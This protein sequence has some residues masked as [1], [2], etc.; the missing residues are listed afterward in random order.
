[1][2]AGLASPA[3]A[4]PHIFVDARATITFDDAGQVVSVHNSWTFD[5]YY[6]SWAVQGLD[7]DLDGTV[8]T[9]EMQPL[10]DDN[11]RGL[12]S[13][14]YYTFAGEGPGN[15]TFGLGRD[16]VMTYVDG[17]QTLD[18]EVPLSAPYM[19]QD[20]LEI[21]VND[22]EYYVAIT[23]ANPDMVKLVN[24]PANCSASLEDAEP[25]SDEL[26]EQLYALGPDVTVLPP[27]L[28]QQMRGVQGSIL[29]SCP[30]GSATG[31][32]I[33][34]LAA[35]EPSVAADPTTALDAVTQMAEATPTVVTTSNRPMGGPPPEPGLVLPKTGFLGWL[36]QAQTDFYKAMVASL[37]ALKQD[38]TGFWVLG[39]LSFL[40]GVLHAAGPGHGKVVI[41]SYV[42]ANEAQA[43]R[44]V[45]LSFLSAMLQSLVAIGFVLVAALVL[46]MT[47]MAMND[48]AHWIGVLSYALIV[49]L[50]LWLIARKVFRLGHQHDHHHE[51]APSMQSLARHHM[52]QPAH[53]LAAGGPALTN[54]TIVEG[55]LDAYGREPGHPHYGHNH[56]DDEHHDHAHVVMPSQTG[57]GWREQLGVVLAVGLR[58]C[59]GALIVLAF[60]LSQGLLAAGIVAVLLMGLGTAITTGTL[61]ALAVGAKGIARKVAGADNPLTATIL[62]W[63]EL[64]GAVAVLGFGAVLLLASL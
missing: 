4:H 64:L 8:T 54:F 46:G 13:Y 36:S 55:R 50:G 3:L 45:W 10:A 27:E 25:M 58:P 47:S 21:A 44:G 38:W 48:A 39:G 33:P 2:G 20:H 9:M 41:G 61:A 51:P 32:P 34:P 7:T 56:G 29:I 30:G 11:M 18:F 63:V 52:G 62:W 37:D 1:M 22:P 28:A 12:Y 53:A 16:A 14:D 42:L 40:Y 49:L 17:R 59:S 31:A 6:S 43:R 23:F 19:I 60:A 26:A 57:G 35:A 24:A 15:L 5:E